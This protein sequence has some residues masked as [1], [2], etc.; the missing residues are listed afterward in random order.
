MLVMTKRS[1]DNI[2]FVGI[3]SDKAIF[4]ENRADPLVN[5]YDIGFGE[6]SDL[7]VD[8]NS[9]VTL[10]S[11]IGGGVLEI[12]TFMPDS[13]TITSTFGSGSFITGSWSVRS[14]LEAGGLEMSSTN[15][16][17]T[18]QVASSKKL[19]HL[20]FEFFVGDVL[21]TVNRLDELEISGGGTTN[22]VRAG[23]DRTLGIS[24]N[25]SNFGMEATFVFSNFTPGAVYDTDDRIVV[26][27]AFV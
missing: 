22:F 23:V 20:M 7:E 12:A 11:S 19:S 13:Q 15:T 9:N 24:P 18:I 3:P 2:H 10:K 8:E 25:G 16:T 21:S 1:V 5:A 27:G 26:S 6:N 17:L 4:R 14:P